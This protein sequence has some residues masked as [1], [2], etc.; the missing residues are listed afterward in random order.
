MSRK[1]IIGL[2]SNYGIDA[3]YVPPRERAYLLAE[4]TDAVATAGGIPHV[5]PVPS[6]P[7]DDTLDQLLQSVDGLVLTGGYDLHPRNWGEEPHPKTI[8]MHPR[9]EAFELA[10]FRRADATRVP[11]LA[12][13]LGFQIAHVI[14]GGR[15]MQHVDDLP[16]NAPL[17]HY[18]PGDANAFHAVRVEPNSQLARIVGATE[19]EIN[20]RHH[21]IVPLEHQGAGLQ[22]V[23]LSPDG[24]LE[25]S[26][27]FDGRFLLAIQWHPEDLYDRPEHLRLFQALV[28]AAAEQRCAR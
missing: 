10:L 11:M 5:L 16:R 27:D 2:T 17:V 14:R 21:Q 26:E 15:L 19:F 24:L 1:P 12:I 6:D 8:P 4:Y 20:S 13:C 23:A 22:Q 3:D 18:L 7:N 25:A 9:R 28:K